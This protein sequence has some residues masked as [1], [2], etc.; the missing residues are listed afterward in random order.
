LVVSSP[1]GIL[2]TGQTTS[3]AT[4]DDGTYQSGL[5]RT[6]T[7]GGTTGLI[8]QRC[9][10]GQNADATCS[11]TASTNTWDQATTYCSGLT[12]LGKTWRLPTI[13][14]LA[15]LVNYGVSSSSKIDSTNFPN[16][17]AASYWS[18]NSGIVDPTLAYYVGFSGGAIYGQ[19]KTSTIYVR[20]VT[21]D[22][23]AS[24]ILTDNGDGTIN[25]STSG[26][27]WQKCSNGQTAPTCSGT[28]TKVAWADS[29]TYCEG[30]TLGGRSDWRLPNANELRNIVDYSKSSSPKIDTN[31]F[32]N[33]QSSEYWSSNTSIQSTNNSWTVRFLDGVVAT[34]GKTTGAGNYVR[35]VAGP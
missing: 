35:C 25:D 3:Y 22:I 5:A 8:F 14:E 13:N 31:F 34:A 19:S 12:L 10:A 23:S 17:P 21:G 29:I 16:N 27:T 30:L 6:F 2:K 18:S 15:N 32:P 28:A 4:G 33:T 1:T 7:P 24:P 11:G 26:R 9:S 20:C